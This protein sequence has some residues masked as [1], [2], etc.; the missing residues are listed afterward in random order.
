ML[1]LHLRLGRPGPL[2]KSLQLQSSS[3]LQLDLRSRFE[4]ERT[5][6]EG[7]VQKRKNL[8]GNQKERRQGWEKMVGY[9][10]SHVPLPSQIPRSALD[11]ALLSVDSS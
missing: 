9:S 6:Y 1:K 5:G 8:E 11:I 10:K 3:D 7:R 4:Q 2:W